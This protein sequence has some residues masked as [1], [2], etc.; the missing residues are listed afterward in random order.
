VRLLPTD[1]IR[2]RYRSS[3][4]D[5][6]VDYNSRTPLRQCPHSCASFCSTVQSCD[7]RCGVSCGRTCCD[8]QARGVYK[9]HCSTVADPPAPNCSPL[10]AARFALVLYGSVG[11]SKS[12]PYSKADQLFRLGRDLPE[13][14]FGDVARVQTHLRAYLFEPSGGAS[15][16]DTFLHS[17]VPSH[18]VQR[19]LLRLYRPLYHRFSNYTLSWQ[20]RIDALCNGDCKKRGGHVE[21]SRWL[22]AAAALRLM[23]RAEETNGRSYGAVYLTRFD[24]LLWANVDLRTFCVGQ[25]RGDVAYT[26]HCHPPFQTSHGAGGS[27]ADF[28]FVLSSRHA[29]GVANITQH[30]ARFDFFLG[31][32][33]LRCPARPCVSDSWHPGPAVL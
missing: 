2:L 22:S 5:S 11:P 17:T 31:M 1:T 6:M 23:F 18:A 13:S 10:A 32:C 27:P 7:V 24:V 26:N 8:F 21:V 14:A 29:R 4:R 12:S 20:P 33:S 25:K 15:V 28:H 9:G 16:W 30:I 19:T 3:H